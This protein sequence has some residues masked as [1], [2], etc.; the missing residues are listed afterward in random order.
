MLKP[1]TLPIAVFLVFLSLFS[2]TLCA[3]SWIFVGNSTPDLYTTNI[4]LNLDATKADGSTNASAACTPATWTDLSG[5]TNTATQSGFNCNASSG[6]VGDGTTGDPYAM[7]FDGTN[8]KMTIPNSSSLDINGDIT[9]CAM[10]NA[11]NNGSDASYHT[12][13][14]KRNSGASKCQYEMF[15]QSSVTAA[16]N[17]SNAGLTG[18]IG[19]FNQNAASGYNLNDSTT[20]VTTSAWHYICVSTSGTTNSFYIDGGAVGTDT[21]SDT[22]RP[23]SQTYDLEVGT[24]STLNEWFVGKIANLHVYNAALTGAQVS[25][26]CNSLKA[27]FS[28]L[29]CS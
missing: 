7:L 24:F 1:I 3:S 27:R 21:I 29:T 11:T 10:I 23:G 2:F 26:N 20:A 15:L 13:I 19:W 17:G 16:V 12:V 18:A 9:L 6:W 28:G 5:N 25:Q 8:D 14:S 4:Q 22:K